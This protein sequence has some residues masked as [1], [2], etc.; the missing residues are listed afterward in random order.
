MGAVGYLYRRTLINRI[1]MAFRRPVTYFYLVI[2]L[3]Y[4]FAMPF[5]LRV[6][7]AQFGADTP[8]GLAG[9]L[10]AVS[11]WLI[12]GNFIAF[13]KRRGLVYRSSDVHFMFPA[14][15]NPK[16]VLIYAYLRMLPAQAI[17]NLFVIFCGLITFD[18]SGWKLLV[19]FLFSVVVENV[20]EGCV[21]LLLYGTE[22]LKERQRGWLKAGAYGLVG[23]LVCIALAFYLRE[24]MSFQ[25]VVHFLHSDLVQMVP[26]IGWYISVIHLLF[27]GATAVNVVG[28]ALYFGLFAAALVA[29]WRMECTGAFYE[30]AIK[31]AEDYEEVL[32]S[33]RQGSTEKRLGRKRRYGRASIRWKG[34]GA[35]AIFYRQ[36]LEYKKS[37]FFFFDASTALSLAAGAGIAWLYLRE[38]GFGEGMPF[39]IPAVSAYLIFL[40]TAMNGKWAKELKTPYTYLIPDTAFAKLICAT[41]IQHIQSLVNALLITLPGA[42]V[43]R[44][45]P[46]LALL[47]ILGFVALS[48]NKLYALAVTQ[49]VVGDTFGT[50]GRQML[51]MLMQGSVILAAA[52]GAVL[53]MMNGGINMAYLMMDVALLLFTAVFMVIASLNFDRLES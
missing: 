2:I 29:A 15:V 53:G 3:F 1:R 38:D 10:T 26:V 21:T 46:A 9:V 51:Q 34:R 30:D 19:Y 45:P 23:L 24:G 13:A 33:R 44:M 11:F 27:T 37:R 31:F 52:L 43:M 18:V 12:P 42:V 16:G 22:R 35:A 25:T 32:A 8:E 17:M 28:A 7:S 40:F 49:I 47:N 50:F 39:V 36:L 48:A 4:L 5:S 14:P 41:S 6:W 20:L